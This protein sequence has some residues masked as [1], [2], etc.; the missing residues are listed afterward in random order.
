MKR[1]ELTFAGLLAATSLA[2][3]QVV[4]PPSADP[5]AIQQR[6]MEEERLRQLRERAQRKQIEEPVQ[7]QLPEPAVPKAAAP[8]ATHFVVKTV[9]FT[10]SEILSQAELASL[11]S[12]VEGKDLDMNGLRQFVDTVNKF[13]RQKGVVTAQAVLPAQDVTS[14]VLQIRLVEGHVGQ[15][16]LSGNTSTRDSYLLNRLGLQSDDL[17]D[18]KQLEASLVRFNRTN[19]VQMQAQLKPGQRFATTDLAVN[20]SEPPAQSLRLSV[21]NLGTSSTGSNRLTLAYQHRSLLGW[22]DSLSLSATKSVG[23]TS[24]AFSYGVPFNT[25]GGRVS[26]GYNIDRT[27][28]E[29]GSLKSLNITGRSESANI[30]A[31]QP[32]LVDTNSELDLVGAAKQRTTTNWIDGV[33]MQKVDTKGLDLGLEGQWFDNHASWFGSFTHSVVSASTPD[34]AQYNIERA[35]LRHQR[36]LENG[37]TFVGN[38]TLQVSSDKLLPSS[39]QFF[40]GGEGSVRG[41]ASGVY[42]GDSGMVLNL[43]LHHS[44]M[45]PG[46]S[47]VDGLSTSG[48]LFLDHGR[49]KPFRPPASSLPTYDTVTGVGLGLDLALGKS[50]QGRVTLGYGLDHVDAQSH[51]LRVTFQLS[52]LLF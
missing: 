46:A 28:I 49:V 2:S 1:H 47:S 52:T 23:T 39:E 33:T 40:L 45:L 37:L 14:G 5:G 20:V 10:P 3:A 7:N 34:T 13:Y 19:D 43:E 8:G 50:T 29:H 35:S 26:V 16:L 11:A 17:V 15:V 18:L 48:F 32:L 21:D 25:S 6:Q 51:N 42:S 38:V 41:Y 9:K 24:L 44:V 22:R 4:V 30:S 36:E 27:S 12:Q 31:R